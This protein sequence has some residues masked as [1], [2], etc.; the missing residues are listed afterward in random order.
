MSHEHPDEEATL[1]PAELNEAEVQLTEQLSM[2]DQLE[3]DNAQAEIFRYGTMHDQDEMR[4]MGV[5]FRR[6]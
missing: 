3:Q 2:D 6:F 4:A 5:R 1:T